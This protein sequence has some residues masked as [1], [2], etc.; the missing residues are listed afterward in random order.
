MSDARI[1]VSRQVPELAQL[2]DAQSRVAEL[3]ATVATLDRSEKVQAALYRIAETA[4][5]AA[6]MPSFYAAMHEI[7]G[8]LMYAD[9]FYIALYDEARQRINYPFFRDEVDSDLPDPNTWEPF[10]TGNAKGATAYV[11][12]TSRS[13]GGIEAQ[14]T[15]MA[16]AAKIEIIGAPSVEWMGVPLMADGR[17]IGVVAV[18]TYR[19]DRRYAPGDLELLTFVGHHIGTG[20]DSRPGDR[21]DP[22]AERGA[23]PRQR[24]RPG[25]RAASS[26]S[27]RSSSSSASAFGDLRGRRSV[28]RP[29]R[30]GDRP[31]HVPVRV[32]RAV[33]VHGASR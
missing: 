1:S 4:S 14:F 26:T 5:T 29:V 32:P 33:S 23:R 10:G 19:D 16:A 17:S 28:H 30:R 18:Q 15:E 8:E 3:E 9:N 21:G 11:L 2:A 27:G 13:H 24:D 22:P 6:D 25:A 12:R 20:A 7:V 31:D